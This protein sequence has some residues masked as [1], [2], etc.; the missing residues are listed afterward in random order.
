MKIGVMDMEERE[1]ARTEQDLADLAGGVD[2]GTTDL[3]DDVYR[4]ETNQ[5]SV[6]E[7]DLNPGLEG[8]FDPGTTDLGD[9]VHRSAG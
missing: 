4:T 9:D 1:Q 8:G 6:L 3:G 7:N 5:G 2:P